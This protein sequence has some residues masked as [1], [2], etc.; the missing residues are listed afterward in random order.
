MHIAHI[1]R[2]GDCV[3]IHRFGHFGLFRLHSTMMSQYSSGRCPIQERLVD[4]GQACLRA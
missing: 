3:Q 2:T 1:G 4:I